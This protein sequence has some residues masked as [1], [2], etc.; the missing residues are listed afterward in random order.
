MKYL[1]IINKCLLEL[2]YKT[3]NSLSELIKNEHKRLIN[4]LNALNKEVCR[5]EKWSFL[6]RR[7]K[8][9]LDAGTTE[10]DNSINGRILYLFIDGQRYDFDENIEKFIEGTPKAFTY[11]VFSKKLLFPRFKEDKTIDV[12]YYTDNCVV[13]SDDNEKTD[14]DDINDT[15]LIPMPF[16]E[17][18]LVY[19]ACM[20][21][22]GNPQHF[23]FSYWMSM[24]KDALQNLKSKTSVSAD[25]TPVVRL[26]RS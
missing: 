6:L 5:C 23:K 24:Y 11:S 9:H 2:N 12:I 14:F 22:K 16:A 26:Y 3:V 21:L 17:Q 18:I 13:D 25:S 15:S 10:I 8:I 20:R 4:I 19:G 7:A 1:E